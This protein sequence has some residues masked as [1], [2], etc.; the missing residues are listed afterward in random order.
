[1]RGF[2]RMRTELTTQPSDILDRRRAV[3]DLEKNLLVLAGAGTGKTTLLVDRLA[4]LIVGK[5]IP[6]ERIVA[7]TFTKKAAEE[8]RVRLEEILRL[9]IRELETNEETL[10]SS[11]LL[12]P[13][14]QEKYSD[15]RLEWKSRAKVALDNIPKA[16]IGTIHSFAGYLLRLYPLQS[17]VDP[18]FIEDEGTLA[19]DALEEA[20]TS[21]VVKEFSERG[22]RTEAWRE[23]LHEISF[24]GMKELARELISPRVDFF[25]LEKSAD[26]KP[27]AASLGD[28]LDKLRSTNPYKKGTTFE[29]A[30]E[31][32]A[33][34]LQCFREGKSIPR[35]TK[36]ALD[37]VF[38]I[39][40][41]W[42]KTP[43]VA[44]EFN[45]TYR[46]ARA[47]S[48]VDEIAVG[49]VRDLLK[50][51]VEKVRSDLE[52]RGAVSFDGLLVKARNLVRDFP[53]VRTALKKQFDAFLIDEFQDTDP[54]QG[55]ILFYLAEDPATTA[56]A[57]PQ[58]SLVPGRLFV[59]G[60]PK[61]SIYR[62]RGADMAAFAAF[63]DKLLETGERAELSQNFRSKKPILDFVNNLTPLLM[64][65]E[66]GFQPPYAALDAA[67]A[68]D[69][70]PAVQVMLID[71]TG[72]DGKLNADDI[73]L[74]EGLALA[75]WIDQQVRSST[76]DKGPRY[77]DFTFL[78]R[79]TFAFRPYLDALRR[80]DIPFLAEGEKYFYHTPEV[81]ELT[82]LLS[83]IHNPDDRI[84][85][86][87]VLRSP[88]GALNDREIFE[89]N[90]K[91]GLD[92]RRTPSLF[93]DRL[94]VLYPILRDLHAASHD[95]PLPL[96]L[97]EVY[98]RTNFLT[99]SVRS[100]QGEQAVANLQKIQ[101]LAQSWSEQSPLSLGD[102]LERFRRYREEEKEEGE[103][104]LADVN[105]DAVRV[106][107]IHKAKGLEFPIVILPDLHRAKRS[108][109]FIPSLT[110]FDWASGRVGLRF[111]G[112]GLTNG[113]M[114][115]NEI[116]APKREEA[117]E[118]RVFYV[119]LTRA[120]DRL[121]L[122]IS[123]ATD[124]G[125]YADFLSTLAPLPK[126]EEKI[127]KAGNAQISVET[128]RADLTALRRSLAPAKSSKD[129]KVDVK[130]LVTL[131]HEREA[132]W[133]SAR[134][135]PVFDSPSRHIGES[136]KRTWP[137]DDEAELAR[138]RA[139]TLGELCHKVLELWNFSTKKVDLK[140]LK[141]TI[142]ESGRLY[143][144]NPKVNADK[145]ILKEAEDILE[146]FFASKTYAYLQSVKIMGKEVPFVYSKSDGGVMRGVIDLLYE[147]KEGLVVADYKTTKVK[148][149]LEKA[150]EKYL[151]QSEA[152]LEA[153]SRVLKKPVRFEVIF[154]RAQA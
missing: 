43:G 48:R 131:W 104:P 24:D 72:A 21:W 14:L 98:S 17:R 81:V 139:T 117:E 123:T 49:R 89:L 29:T 148:G 33:H 67:R 127:W 56:D 65:E 142:E 90:K 64:K 119:A 87:G 31:A 132:E 77:G 38:T 7:L 34:T 9:L 145:E 112:T 32:A 59:V 83:A 40:S 45:R 115:L 71:P 129:R 144:L 28:R 154:L 101:R 150:A 147:V 52:R 152:Y 4:L 73:R 138:D 6:V 11:S 19:N 1:M 121:V 58:V 122:P 46:L 20:W 47:L 103:N 136:E 60:D 25:A 107:T 54:L 13:L 2:T 133:E 8:M 27:L 57:W 30:L 16:Q 5:G 94:G 37:S 80:R 39:A 151:A 96:F 146:N 50:P 78:F 68:G 18:R 126:K 137:E 141:R 86:V 92:Y 114:V 108:F 84:A 3:G 128:H 26:L 95:R 140:I 93:K 62:F 51:L 74:A 85:L 124:G 105:Y 116:H 55:E 61:Q 70:S 149:D 102:F 41:E 125:V 12:R 44:A 63:G 113:A 135:T 69:D 10:P 23:A 75:E 82:A 110:D 42:K 88:L 53:L 66:A 106:M 35:E 15:A 97:D 120:K 118:V 109:N 130:E 22:R 100:L 91:V 134:A 111:P 153:V 36:S 76:G 99:L 79:S 143:D